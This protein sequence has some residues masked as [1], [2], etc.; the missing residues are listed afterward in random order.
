MITTARATQKE[1]SQYI[2]MYQWVIEFN[3]D[4]IWLEV[5][6][7]H[8][9]TD[10]DQ[11]FDVINDKL[12]EICEE[13]LELNGNLW[14]DKFWLATIVMQLY[15]RAAA[16]CEEPY[17]VIVKETKGLVQDYLE[18]NKTKKEA[19]DRIKKENDELDKEYAN[20]LKQQVKKKNRPAPKQEYIDE[21]Q[22]V[23]ISQ[24]VEQP[25]KETPKEKPVK[26]KG[27]WV[28]DVYETAV[29]FTF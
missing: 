8:N 1:L 5:I 11:M 13:Y 12:I 23:E 20:A 15:T 9:K 26:R 7:K 17:K 28:K 29:D 2:K 21:E 19:L 25:K 14:L 3:L 4:K 16:E 18:K 27:A 24:V 10:P 22:K 6:I